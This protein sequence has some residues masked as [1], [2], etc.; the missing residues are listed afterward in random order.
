MIYLNF[1]LLDR[2]EIWIQKRVL[3]YGQRS[4]C[5]VVSGKIAHFRR[6]ENI[7]DIADGQVLKIFWLVVTQVGWIWNQD[8][9]QGP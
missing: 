8:S 3:S 9:L 4:L 1:T 6:Y 5:Q 7:G 2:D